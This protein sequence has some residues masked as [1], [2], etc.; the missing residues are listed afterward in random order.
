MRQQNVRLLLTFP[1]PPKVADVINERP[2]TRM[3]SPR[4]TVFYFGL[5]ITLWLGEVVNFFN[6]IL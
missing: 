6:Q 5:K 2:L 4:K 3:I 1:P